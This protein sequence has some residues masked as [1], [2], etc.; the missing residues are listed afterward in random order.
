LMAKK[1]K[2]ATRVAELEAAVAGLFTGTPAAP[3]KKKR[4]AKTRKAKTV[5]AAKAVARKAK[6]AV[7]K[8]VKKARR[9]AKRR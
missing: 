4:R 1:S 9:T 8:R 2:L 3:V 6:K 7:K 5:K